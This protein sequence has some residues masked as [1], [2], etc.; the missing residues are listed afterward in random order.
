MILTSITPPNSPT[1][2][3]SMERAHE[4]LDR[5]SIFVCAETRA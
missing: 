5:A 1:P 3:K 4:L 2:A